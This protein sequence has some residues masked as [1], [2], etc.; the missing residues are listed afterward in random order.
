MTTSSNRYTISGISGEFLKDHDLIGKQDPY[1]IFEC[2]S[3]KVETSVSECPIC[4]LLI[5]SCFAPAS[6][7]FTVACPI[8]SQVCRFER[9]LD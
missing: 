8:C 9:Y 3:Q 1:V 2:G 4:L 6:P 5:S 7:S